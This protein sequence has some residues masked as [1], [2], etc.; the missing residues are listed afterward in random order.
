MNRWLPGK[1][2]KMVYTN[3]NT[4]S[5]SQEMQIRLPTISSAK[6]KMFD[7]ASVGRA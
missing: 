4:L 6:I 2:L 3:E 5:L 7:K 1:D